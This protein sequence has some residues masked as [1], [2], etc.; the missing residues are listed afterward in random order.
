MCLWCYEVP[1]DAMRSST[2]LAWLPLVSA[3]IINSST[4]SS[5]SNLSP[6]RLWYHPP[7][8]VLHW[9]RGCSLEEHSIG[10][11]SS[12]SLQSPYHPCHSL[13][14]LEH[15]SRCSHQLLSSRPPTALQTMWLWHFIRSSTRI[16]H[17]NCKLSIYLFKNQILLITRN[18]EYGYSHISP[19]MHCS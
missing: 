7:A 2:K 15:F 12:Y 5:V 13:L 8:H 14:L 16:F 17:Q 1:L 11:N 3:Q 9:T 4:A 19:P 18:T 10:P 6:I